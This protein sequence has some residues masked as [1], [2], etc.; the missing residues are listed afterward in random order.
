MPTSLP[1]LVRTALARF[2]DRVRAEI[3][4]NLVELRLFGSYARG[5]AH[6]ESDV[7]VCVVLHSMTWE[8]RRAILDLGADVFLDLDVQIS[9]T[10]L[11]EDQYRLWRRQD[12]SLVRDIEREGVRL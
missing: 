4:A 12:R 3:G 1:P 5:E 9:P 6:E 10:V 8:N 7:D 11:S 2:G